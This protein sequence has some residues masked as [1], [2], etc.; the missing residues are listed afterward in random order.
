[1]AMKNSFRIIVAATAFIGFGLAAC[2]DTPGGAPPPPPPPLPA[3]EGSPIIYIGNVRAASVQ[4]GAD[5]TVTIGELIGGTG[6]PTARWYRVNGEQRTFLNEGLNHTVAA[7]EPGSQLEVTVTRSGAT[8]TLSTPRVWIVPSNASQLGGSVSITGGDEIQATVATIGRTLTASPSGMGEGQLSFQWWHIDQGDNQTPIPGATGNT[9]SITHAD[10][11]RD[12]F[13]RVTSSLYLG[14]RDSA[15][16]QIPLLPLPLPA[17][18]VSIFSE[19]PQTGNISF[20]GWGGRG[21]RAN[22]TKAFYVAQQ[23]YSIQVGSIAAGGQFTGS[24]PVLED[25]QL[26]SFESFSSRWWRGPDQP[27]FRPTVSNSSVRIN[28]FYNFSTGQ[29][30]ERLLRGNREVSVTQVRF[31]S[32][33]YSVEYWFVSDDVNITFPAF[34]EEFDG[35][36]DTRVATILSLRR[37]WNTVILRYAESGGMTGGE[38]IES[39]HTTVPAATLAS[40][41]WFVDESF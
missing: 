38:L 11:G 27:D 9:H 24:L 18:P 8:G 40:L 39:L 12:I 33:Q 34:R 32:S 31:S 21:A 35:W 30:A 1:M 22:V 13:V 29:Q 17:G 5:L 4:A 19:N 36:I 14:F 6:A 20:S 28:Y 23:D 37:G 41:R 3:L 16:T 25:A 10:N 15:P 26:R 2:G 7:A